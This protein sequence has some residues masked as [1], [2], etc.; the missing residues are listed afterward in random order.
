MPHPC[1]I[2]LPHAKARVLALIQHYCDRSPTH[3]RPH[4]SLSEV[5]PPAFAAC[6]IPRDTPYGWHLLT[7]LRER[8]V[9][10]RRS[11]FPLLA[12]VVVS[13]N[14][15][16]PSAAFGMGF[17]FLLL[18]SLG[19]RVAGGLLAGC[20]WRAGGRRRAIRSSLCCVRAGSVGTGHPLYS[21]SLPPGAVSPMAI[22]G[23]RRVRPGRSLVWGLTQWSSRTSRLSRPRGGGAAVPPGCAGGPTTVPGQPAGSS[24]RVA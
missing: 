20:S 23:V 14:S 3:H 19:G 18:P 12:S 10:L 7:T 22:A 4:V 17:A 24:C 15:N 8:T 9:A 16:K 21:R 5:L 13:E 6:G 1:G 2:S 11:Q